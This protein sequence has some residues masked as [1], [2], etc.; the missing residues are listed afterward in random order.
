ME[1][2]VAEYDASLV[3]RYVRELIPARDVPNCEDA[4]IAGAQARVHG[5]ALGRMLDASRVKAK[6][7]HISAPPRGD[8]E[9]RAGDLGR[10]A[11]DLDLNDHAVV[12][13]TDMD[14]LGSFP[15]RH[16]LGGKSSTHHSYSFRVILWQ[17][18]PALKK[19]DRSAK[20]AVRLS[21]LDADRAAADHH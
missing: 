1:Q 5:Y 17:N 4:S 14:D 3:G 20:A 10:S 19:S 9:M 13:P 6:P 11:V 2:R 21:H 16:A 15:D 8:E 18:A 7:F 12:A